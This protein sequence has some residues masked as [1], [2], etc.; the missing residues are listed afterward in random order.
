MQLWKAGSLLNV[1]KLYEDQRYS[2]GLGQKK[3][4]GKDGRIICSYGFKAKQIIPMSNEIRL[5]IY[6]ITQDETGN[7]LEANYFNKTF[8]FTDDKIESV[9][10]H[11][12]DQDALAFEDLIFELTIDDAPATTFSKELAFKLPLSII[13]FMVVRPCRTESE[14]EEQWTDRLA[15]KECCVAFCSDYALDT[16]Y[17]S[18]P[19][20]L[21]YFFAGSCVMRDSCGILFEVDNGVLMAMV[22]I[23]IKKHKIFDLQMLFDESYAVKARE[24]GKQLVLCFTNFH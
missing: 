20:D 8:S 9:I 14:F 16:E 2:I 7:Q 11:T 10:S 19:T 24:L 4:L 13:N 17:A 3:A 22:R 5:R 6:V 15:S 23:R 12:F 21:S 18:R 1:C